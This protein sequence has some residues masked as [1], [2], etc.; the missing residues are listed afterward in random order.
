MT[1]KNK[2]LVKKNLIHIVMWNR[3]L[4][5]YPIKQYIS[6]KNIWSICFIKL[7]Q[8]EPNN[9]IHLFQKMIYMDLTNEYDAKY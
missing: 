9:Q 5:F 1:E 8:N 3:F 2:L 7:L 4:I 6:L